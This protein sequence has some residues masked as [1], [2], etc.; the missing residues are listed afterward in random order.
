M[1]DFEKSLALV[2]S[3]EEGKADAIILLQGDGYARA[4]HAVRLF[5]RGLAPRVV[6]LAGINN[7]TGGGFYDLPDTVSELGVPKGKILVIRE[8]ASTKEEAGLV[9]DMA[10]K[11]GWGR[12]IIVTSPYHQLRAFLTY[13]K[14]VDDRKASLKIMNSAARGLPWFEANPWGRRFDLLSVEKKKI[15]KYVVEGDIATFGRLIEYYRQHD[16]N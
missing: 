3:G 4:P 7:K 13:L 12:I 5:K 14:T 11:E 16:G 6:I 8:G 9:I 2:L 15:E 10:Q 1:T